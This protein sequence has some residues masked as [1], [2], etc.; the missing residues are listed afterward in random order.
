MSIINDAIKKARREFEIRS[1]RTAPV[2][3][4]TLAKESPTETTPKSSETKWTAAV[5]VSLVLIAS[6]LGSIF[7]YSHMSRLNALHSPAMVSVRKEAPALPAGGR[8]KPARPVARIEDIVELN[9]IVY[10]P[11]DKWAIINNKIAREGNKVPGGKLIEIAKDFVR[12]E[13]DNGEELVLEL[14]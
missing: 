7:L 1:K 8:Q 12:I 9:G 6:L 10:G 11:D 4:D 14:R 5:V 2:I 3:T 13:K